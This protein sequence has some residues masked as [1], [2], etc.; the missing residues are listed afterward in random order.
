MAVALVLAEGLVLS[1][2]SAAA[3]EAVVRGARVAGNDRDRGTWVG[4]RARVVRAW[5]PFAR[6]KVSVAWLYAWPSAGPWSQ[7]APL[8]ELSRA[9]ADNVAAA[10]GVVGG[11]WQVATLRYDP[12]LHGPVAW[13]ESGAAAATATRDEWPSLPDGVAGE[14]PVGPG[15]AARGVEVA[16]AHTPTAAEVLGEALDTAEVLADAAERARQG[17]ASAWPWVAAAVALGLGGYV[18]LQTRPTRVVLS[19]ESS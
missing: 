9:L 4:P 8:R 15:N 18:W 12:A 2:P 7:G 10:L 17:A 16:A 1:R 3:L 5:N 6:G 19:Q 14:N 13:W 11:S